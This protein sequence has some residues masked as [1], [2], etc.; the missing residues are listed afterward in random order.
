MI[1]LVLALAG[2]VEVMA[3]LRATEARVAEAAAARH[4][5]THLRQAATTMAGAT[6]TRTRARPAAPPLPSTT[7]RPPHPGGPERGR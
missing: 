5:G 1:G 6:T 7:Y 2:L 3:E 4:A